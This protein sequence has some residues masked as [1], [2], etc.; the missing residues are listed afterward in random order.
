MLERVR[1]AHN[2]LRQSTKRIVV[3]RCR[4][5]ALLFFG[6]MLQVLKGIPNE[7]NF[8]TVVR[9]PLSE[10]DPKAE[11]LKLTPGEAVPE[12]THIHKT[13]VVEIGEYVDFNTGQWTLRIT[14]K[15]LVKGQL[16]D[17]LIVSS[18][19]EQFAVHLAFNFGDMGMVHGGS[20][21]KRVA[22]N[23][24]LVP[25]TESEHLE[26][27]SA[28]F[29]YLSE[30]RVVLFTLPVMIYRSSKHFLLQSQLLPS[31]RCP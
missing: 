7:M 30:D 12:I 25:A 18:S 2:W 3:Q 27:Y 14:A 29:F 9:S 20:Y 28:H 19:K 31:Y 8:C 5:Y 11:T 22:F 13:A 24:L 26:S 10:S 17:S 16:P 6:L 1:L 23:E 4:W 15:D 21:T